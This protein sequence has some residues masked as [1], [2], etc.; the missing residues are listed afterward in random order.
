MSSVESNQASIAASRFQSF[1]T[2]RPN[3]LFTITTLSTHF[4]LAAQ[5]FKQYWS[6][7]MGFDF[8]AQE[9]EV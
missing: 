4:S 3:R 5:L 8:N 6:D 9:I 1:Y 2:T 7:I